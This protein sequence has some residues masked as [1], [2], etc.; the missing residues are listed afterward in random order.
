MGKEENLRSAA[1]EILERID[2]SGGRLDLK[3]V[4]E[5][6]LPDFIKSFFEL[7]FESLY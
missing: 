1:I 3:T 4:K 2:F 5:S 7:Q 6:D